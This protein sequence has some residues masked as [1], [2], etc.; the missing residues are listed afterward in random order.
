MLFEAS[1]D[2][3]AGHVI[4]ALS[5][6]SEVLELD[7]DRVEAHL[8]FGQ[9]LSRGLEERV[10]DDAKS[11]A[12]NAMTHFRWVLDRDPENQEARA[13][14]EWLE[15]LS[16]QSSP[17][18]TSEAGIRA[19]AKAQEALA[20][21]NREDAIAPLRDAVAAEPENPEVVHVHRLLGKLLLET[22]QADEA[23]E[24]LDTAVS[25]GAN[26]DEIHFLLGQAWE[27]KQ[28]IPSALD[29]YSEALEYNSGNHEVVDRVVAL[30]GGRE[31]EDLSPGELSL[32]GRAYVNGEQYDKGVVVLDEALAADS[33]FASRKALGIAEF[34]R[35]NDERAMKVLQGAHAADPTDLEV[36]YYIGAVQ[37]RRGDTDAGRATLRDLLEQDPNN[38][39]AMRLLGL[40][41]SED[42]SQAQS[43]LRYLKAAR[44]A[45]A[46]I[47]G[48]PCL[49]GS[50]YMQLGQQ[51]NASTMFL[52]CID[53]SPDFSG[54]YLGLGIVADDRGR[55]RDAIQY[56]QEYLDREP[57]PDRGAAFRLGVAYLKSGQD[58]KGFSTLR[59]IV[60]LGG[61]AEADAAAP[62]TLTDTELLEATSFFLASARRFEDAIF[63]GE[64]LLTKNPDNAVYNN[65]LAMSY[66]D[67]NHKVGRAHALAVKA[68]YLS[69]DNPG[70]MDTLGW[71]LIRMNRL[72][73][74]EKTLKQSLDMAKEQELPNLSEIYYHLGVLYHQL[75][76]H[77]E[78]LD[79]LTLALKDPPTEFLRR[80]IERVAEAARELLEQEKPTV[81]DD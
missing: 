68:N 56:L 50:L 25:L 41:L 79:Y 31:R 47:A 9:T 46:V 16:I 81:K 20:H 61:Q 69:P 67:A 53:E 12:A 57:D 80:E 58:Q 71:T 24:T 43:A 18:L 33:L 55:T 21:G 2:L 22:G 26:D 77:Q 74:A 62:D 8:L 66:A 19:W 11:A 5:T 40:S 70:H 32:L 7:P 13:G 15:R 17:Y 3:E 36:R 23:I 78:S 38:P 59:R 76:R 54:A 60:Q 1:M 72:D 44:R 45:G 42:P 14:L 34:F 63:I 37:L 52:Q 73:E 39:N 6:L 4:E 48:Y 64:M 49:I 27:K 75:Q 28:D 65:N 51:F 35:R 30:L 29:H 10:F